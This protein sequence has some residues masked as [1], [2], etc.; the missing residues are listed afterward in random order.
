MCGGPPYWYGCEGG[1][2][3]GVLGFG[4]FR[5]CVHVCEGRGLVF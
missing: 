3:F 1:E 2:E 5:V 4:G